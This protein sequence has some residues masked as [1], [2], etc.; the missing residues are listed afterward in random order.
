[1]N[2]STLAFVLSLILLLLVLLRKL[3]WGAKKVRC[4]VFELHDRLQSALVDLMQEGEGFVVVDVGKN[5]IQFCPR[6][7]G[8]LIVDV[9]TGQSVCSL[10]VYESMEQLGFE[11]KAL[12]NPVDL[13]N[14]EMP[15]G[16]LTS[17]QKRTK[18]ALEAQLSAFEVIYTL[19]KAHDEDVVSLLMDYRKATPP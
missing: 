1:M 10:E 12:Y 18:T 16:P 14:N 4:T 15:T 5:F 17:Y 9:P 13:N 2:W 7:D 3:L 8:G 19:F 11:R 6:R